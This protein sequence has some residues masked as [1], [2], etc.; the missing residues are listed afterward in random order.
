MSAPASPGPAVTAI[1]SMSSMVNSASFRAASRTGKNSVTCARAAISGMTPPKATC[2]SMDEATWWASGLV[3]AT[4]PMPVSSHEV[5]IPTTMGTGILLLAERCGAGWA[6]VDE[7]FAH[8]PG[9]DTTRIV[10]GA[11]VDVAES[12]VGIKLLGHGVVGPE[13]RQSGGQG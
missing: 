10:P 9:V 11:G 4:M 5:S 2:S 8:D 13:V 3:P 1:A 7:A 12:V 6:G